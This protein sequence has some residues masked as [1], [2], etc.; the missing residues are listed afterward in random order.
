MSERAIV[1]LNVVGFKAAAVAIKDTTLKG[2]PLV[3]AGSTGG[4]AL[5][6]DCSREAIKEGITLGMNLAEAGKLVK[7]LIVLPPDLP[8][9]HTLNI[10]ME[11][12]ISEYAPAWENDRE[13]NLYLDLTGTAGLFGPATDCTSRILREIYLNTDLRPTAAVAVNKLVS[14]TATRAIRPM[15]LIH[16]QTGT[17]ADFLSHQDIRILPGIGQGLI[18]TAAAVGIQEI[19]EI[20]SL[21]VN[22]VLALFGKNGQVLRSMAQGVDDTPVETGGT[23]RSVKAQ[24]DFIE[25]VLDDNKI[26]GAIETLAEH[27][28]LQDLFQF[29]L[30]SPFCLKFA[31][32]DG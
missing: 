28:G 9:Y 30:C 8:T 29:F 31:Y 12:V 22:Q 18:K 15:G 5:T 1:H 14:K 19:G 32:M 20:A 24:V 21:S 27:C 23:E 4:R 17:E 2:R 7:D 10:E 16:V 6:I 13:G 26:R 3:I 25:D 11:R